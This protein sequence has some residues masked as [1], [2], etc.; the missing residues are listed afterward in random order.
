M[1]AAQQAVLTTDDVTAFGAA[2]EWTGVRDDDREAWLDLR[3]T[4]LTASDVAA[5]LGEDPRRDAYSVYV[6]KVTP[7]KDPER[8]DIDDPRF[9]GNVLEQPIARAVADYYGWEF[10]RGGF[11]LRS[12]QHPFLGCTL[13]AE[14]RRTEFEGW[15]PYEGKT[16]RIP[17]GWDEESGSLPTHILVQA[18]VQLLVTQAPRDLVFGLLQGSRPA[19]IPVEPYA[20]F[21]ALVVEECERFMELVRRGEPP[22]P[23]AAS[24]PAIERLYP[25]GDGSSVLLPIEAVEWTR[26]IQALNAQ[27]KEI[28]TRVD[29]LKNRLRAHIGPATFGELSEPVEGKAFWRYQLQRREQYTVSAS[30]SRVLLAMKNGPA[31]ATKALPASPAPIALLPEGEDATVIRFKKSRKGTRR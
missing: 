21:H 18:Q 5:I 29:E 24:R 28:E 20:E 15:I 25:E 17:R 12:R 13:D 30:E 4:M 26:E 22:T 23:T 27:M 19:Q 3:R 1:S 6:D 31:S 9:W 2:A 14:I 8:L 16:T 10:R 7:R 11:L